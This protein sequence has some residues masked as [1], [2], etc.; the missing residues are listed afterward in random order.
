[1][2]L[3]KLLKITPMTLQPIKIYTLRRIPVSAPNQFKRFRIEQNDQSCRFVVVKSEPL[4]ECE[5]QSI[6][7]TVRIRIHIIVLYTCIQYNI[8]VLLTCIQHMYVYTAVQDVY[9]H[10]CSLSAPLLQKVGT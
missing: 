3:T 4:T 7:Y 10:S 6:R 9:I 1:M 8:I 5:V 2:I